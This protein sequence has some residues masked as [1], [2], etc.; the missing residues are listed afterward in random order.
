M[1][2]KRCKANNGGKNFPS[3]VLHFTSD[4]YEY[5]NRRSAALVRVMSWTTATDYNICHS[6]VLRF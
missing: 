4:S 5:L 1:E 2:R 6:V 3:E